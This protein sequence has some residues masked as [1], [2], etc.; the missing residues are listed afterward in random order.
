MKICVL[1][2]TSIHEVEELRSKD[3]PPQRARRGGKV[4]CRLPDIPHCSWQIGP[5]SIQKPECESDLSMDMP[6][7]LCVTGSPRCIATPNGRHWRS[8]YPRR[9]RGRCSLL[10]CVSYCRRRRVGEDGKSPLDLRPI[11]SSSTSSLGT[12]AYSLCARGVR[13][14]RRHRICWRREVRIMRHF[15]A[16]SLAMSRSASATPPTRDTAPVAS[17]LSE[18]AQIVPNKAFVWHS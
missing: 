5:R 18:S 6:P 14:C 7:T 16:R 17:L 10:E 8:T 12:P 4:V 15:L 3:I 1:K 2:S 11:L 9:K 13:C